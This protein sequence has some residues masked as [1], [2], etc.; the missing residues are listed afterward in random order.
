MWFRPFWNVVLGPAPTTP[1]FMSCSNSRP[2]YPR[3]LS[4]RARL[5]CLAKLDRVRHRLVQ[6]VLVEFAFREADDDASNAVADEIGQRAAF[7][8]E[9]VDTHQNSDR[10]DRDVG[11]DRKRRGQADEAGAGHARGALRG[12]HGDAKNAK[13][14]PDREI[15]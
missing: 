4:V 1:S 8:H 3:P 15:C 9:L 12:D 13:F 2:S 11:H 5:K 7:A 10:L 6:F 14:L